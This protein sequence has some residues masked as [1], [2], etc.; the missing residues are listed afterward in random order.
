MPGV[1]KRGEEIRDFILS[2]ITESKNIAVLTAERFGI[3]LPAVYKLSL[4][5]HNK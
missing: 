4:Y 3:S 5:A 2:N 1:R